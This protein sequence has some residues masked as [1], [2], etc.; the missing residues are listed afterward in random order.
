M[1]AALASLL[2]C[3]PLWAAAVPLA[4][5]QQEN[6]QQLASR[7]LSAGLALR[8][9]GKQDE[10]RV[11]LASALE[12]CTA[13]NPYTFW[14]AIALAEIERDEE[15]WSAAFELMQRALQSL[16]APGRLRTGTV[17][18][19][20]MARAW[21]LG[22][23]GETWI[24]LGL[25]DLAA[26]LFEQERALVDALSVPDA[27][28]RRAVADHEL[29]LELAED[30]I[31]ALESAEQRLEGED[32]YRAQPQAW[33]ARTRLQFAV[34][35]LEAELR[36][37]RPRGEARA[38]LEDLLAAG[39]LEPHEERWAQL[40]LA[41]ALLDEGELEP[42]LDVLADLRDLLANEGGAEPQQ[43]HHRLALALLALEARHARLSLDAG[44]DPAVPLAEHL[45]RLERVWNDAFLARWAE[46]PVRSGGVGYLYL[47]L[48]HLVAQELVELRLRLAGPE[49]GVRA[50]IADLM[51]AQ[52]LGTLSRRLGA[53][54]PTLDEVRAHVL[55]PEGGLLWWHVGRDRSF[56]FL[57]DREG[58][59]CERLAPVHALEH[60][61]RELALASQR[62]LRSGQ[63]S[64]LEAVRAAARAAA[65]ALLPKTWRARVEGWRAAQLVGLDGIGYVPVELFPSSDGAQ[66]GER[67][68]LGYLP[69]IPVGRCLA[70]RAA[71]SLPA[72]DADEVW[73]VADTLERRAELERLGLEPLELDEERLRPLAHAAGAPA[74]LSTGAAATADELGRAAAAGASVLQVVAHGLF[75]LRRERA[76]GL[77]L[78]PDED[79]DGELWPEEVEGADETAPRYPPLVVLLACG[80]ALGPL[81]R[82]DDGR[83]D[84]GAAFLLRGANAVV[85]SATA[86]ERDAGLRSA[87]ALHAGLARGES[88]AA[89]LLALRRELAARGSQLELLQA[90]LLHVLGDAHR[91]V[92]SATAP[93]P[94]RHGAARGPVVLGAVVGVLALGAVLLAAARRSRTAH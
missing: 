92:F 68:A 7:E 1:R 90:C 50:A 44:A 79:G 33:R 47:S 13:E 21:Y 52:A 37:V 26:G 14:I 67:L 38:R 2:A 35:R 11:Q 87:C 78:A 77:L 84:L 65:D 62:A 63:G 24:D 82:G 85:L 25:P 45:A 58:V 9:A 41:W 51:R 59:A 46:A 31:D 17:N 43:P 39:D 19:V 16:E 4:R 83:G 71:A 20:Q 30:D 23:L 3:A 36:E 34:G 76:A 53:A 73:I 10:A 72:P 32:W 75:D 89:A 93:A 12:D 49:S 22:V 55:A 64:D 54:A 57:I 27:N 29:R 66:L 80:T 5:S 91:P 70:A 48:R 18:E 88:P 86:Q 15:H 56:A 94:E 28:M 8:A 42:A 69:S 61:A 60:A 6:A 40:H 81:R 74:H